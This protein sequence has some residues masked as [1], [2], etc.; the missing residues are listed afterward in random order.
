[1]V[2]ITQISNM[3]LDLAWCCLWATFR[4]SF[5]W[6]WRFLFFLAFSFFL[7]VAFLN[8]SMVVYALF[9][10]LGGHSKSM[11]AQ[12]SRV[13]STSSPS[14]LFSLVRFRALPSHKTCSFW[15]ELML[16]PSI[17]ILVKCREKKLIMSTSIVGWTQRVF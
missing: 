11:F 14:P 12:D 1:M 17:S 16:S 5:S 10:Q 4:W 9:Q 13:S 8:L 3:C 2:S 6:K 15:L 7:K